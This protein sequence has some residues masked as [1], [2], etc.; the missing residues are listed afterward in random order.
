MSSCLGCERPTLLRC[1]GS[2]A[3][4]SSNL[5]DKTG[6]VLTGTRNEVEIRLAGRSSPYV[7]RKGHVHVRRLV[8]ES[9]C[10][11]EIVTTEVVA[12]F[13]EGF[14]RARRGGIGPP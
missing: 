1:S 10:P 4:E 9:A 3:P 5:G 11:Y 7:R 6:Y 14:P 8:I 12:T 13:D 2:A